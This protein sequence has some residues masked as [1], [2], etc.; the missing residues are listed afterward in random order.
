M[1]THCKYLKY[2]LRH[3]YYVF[4]ECWKYHEWKMIWRGLVHDLSKFRPS[5]WIPYTDYFYGNYP[6]INDIY[7][8][9]RN[10]I[11]RWKEDVAEEFDNAWLIH[12]HRNPHHW[13]FWVLYYDDGGVG[14]REMPEEYVKEMLADWRGAG[15]AIK[16]YDETKEWYL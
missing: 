15:R 16:G 3:K 8:D 11:S 4:V 12:I 1:N 6:S 14:A 2:V 13:Q 10:V 5:E 7:G 9:K